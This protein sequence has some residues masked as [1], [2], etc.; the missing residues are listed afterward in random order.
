MLITSCFCLSFLS[1]SVSAK[2]FDLKVYSEGP[3]Q[4]P[5]LPNTIHH[6]LTNLG[7]EKTIPIALDRINVYCFIYIAYEQEPE[8]LW[9]DKTIPLTSPEPSRPTL[10]KSKQTA[11]NSVTLFWHPESMIFDRIGKW[12][13]RVVWHGPTSKV[14]SELVQIVIKKPDVDN[15]IALKMLK[16]KNSIPA[17]WGPN[18]KLSENKNLIK[19]WSQ[20]ALEIIERHPSSAYTKRLKEILAIE[21]SSSAISKE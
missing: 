15:Q 16:D 14:S 2:D 6:S 7:T 4:Y 1:Q 9:V 12:T 8:F 5:C 18:W 17:L 19:S 10:F 21:T 13:V 3:E 11:S 20:L